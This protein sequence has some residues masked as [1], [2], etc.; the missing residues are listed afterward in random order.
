MFISVT[1]YQCSPFH[2]SI[3]TPYTPYIN[4]NTH[5]QHT[6]SIPP[7]MIDAIR[8]S[9]SAYPYRVTHAGE[10]TSYITPLTHSTH[11]F[12]S[13]FLQHSTHTLLS[14]L[15]SH[16]LI[17]SLTLFNPFSTHRFSNTLSHALFHMQSL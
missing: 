2:L 15:H 5:L 4:T 13:H 7:G 12:H 14:T 10:H 6:P 17:H 9:R 1:A 11:T 16:P 3:L 8:I